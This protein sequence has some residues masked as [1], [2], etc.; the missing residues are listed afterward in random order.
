MLKVNVA[1][2]KASLGKAK[3]LA[4][5]LQ[6]Q[7]LDLSREDLPL[8]GTVRCEGR[9]TNTGGQLLLTARL[10]ARVRRSCAR[11]LKAF[12]AETGCR[13]QEQFYPAAAAPPEALT[14]VGD[15]L[16][17]AQPLREA[18]LLA[19]P[20]RALCKEDCKGLCPK[21]G[22]DLNEGDCGCAR[23]GLDPRLALLAQLNH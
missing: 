23:Q 19:E 16:D 1:E 8:E 11:C 14:Y 12:S 17:L 21:C 18:L 3:L 6:P 9:L 2:L 22:A 20:L 10:K 7:E 4:Y 5:D 13:V 15:V